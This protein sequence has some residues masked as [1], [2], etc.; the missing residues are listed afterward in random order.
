[1][2]EESVS[3]VLDYFR[4]VKEQKLAAEHEVLQFNHQTLLQQQLMAQQ[5]TRFS[6]EQLKDMTR[7]VSSSLE[8]VASIEERNDELEDFRRD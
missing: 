1:M 8:K 4:E 5:H 2:N 6:V 3:S 7:G